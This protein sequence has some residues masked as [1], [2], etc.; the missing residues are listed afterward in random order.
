MAGQRQA[1]HS[2]C[3]QKLRQVIHETQWAGGGQ[4]I[5]NPVSRRE[6]PLTPKLVVTA[7]RFSRRLQA[8]CS[9][10]CACMRTYLVASVVS[11]SATPWL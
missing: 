6:L 10:V 5:S 8:H 7:S 11:D 4:Q 3:P 1:A 9:C 2:G